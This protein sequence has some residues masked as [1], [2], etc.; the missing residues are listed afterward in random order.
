M[1]DLN[2]TKATPAV[3]FVNITKSF[4]QHKVLT[5]VSLT[6]Y[7]G[8]IIA[9]MGENGA[10]KSTLMRL[11]AGVYPH[12]TY[13]G[14]LRL[15][16]NEMRFHSVR[17]SQQAGVAMIHQEL[18]LFPEL[19]VAENILL[20]E[21][22]SSRHLQIRWNSV[23]QEAQNYIDELGFQLNAKTLVGDLSTGAAQLVEITRALRRNANILIMDEPTSALTENETL[24]LFEILR[25]LQKEGKT[26]FYV[27][28]RME[29]IAQICNKTVVLRDGIIAGI[30]ETKNLTKDKIIQWMVGRSVS[31]IYPT[32][33]SIVKYDSKPL[34]KVKNFSLRDLQTSTYRVKNVS[35]DLYAGEVL[36]FG[37]LMGAGRS[38]LALALFGYFHRSSTWNP[39]Q[40]AISG[41]VEFEGTPVQWQSPQQALK[42]K[43]ALLTEDR[44]QLG[45]CWNRPASEN[46]TYAILPSLSPIYKAGAIDHKLEYDTVQELA[47]DLNVR[48]PGISAP[49]E[50]Y[51]GGNQQKVYLAR[52]LAIKPKLLILDEPTRGVDIGA[53]MEIYQLISKLSEQGIGLILISSEMPELLG[54]SD[55]VAVLQQGHLSQT[56]DKP[57]EGSFNPEAIMHAASL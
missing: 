18:G 24:K 22:A 8:E 40:Y 5:G 13:E 12:D 11:L 28:H 15:G 56:F 55:R 49:I 50:N 19:T 29:E 30:E 9:L 43:V 17:A 23:F 21:L 26:I 37:G 14:T 46:M 27:S 32:R 33:K 48:G 54:L 53:K 6:A 36:G 51:S 45:L 42:D 38:E 3:E 44:K 31:Q 10:G 41:E 20:E 16:G 2:Q 47:R 25:R 52:C 7:P 39:N 1:T 4:G 57:A 35:F 34:L